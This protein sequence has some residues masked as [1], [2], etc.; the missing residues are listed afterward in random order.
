MGKRRCDGNL[1][2]KLAIDRVSKRPRIAD[3]GKF[4]RL[5]LG[6]RHSLADEVGEANQRQGN[7]ECQQSQVM[8][9]RG[10]QPPRGTRGH[11]R[12]R[13]CGGGVHV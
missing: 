6:A 10:T 9:D 11:R 2:V 13:R 7:N 5:A 12:H 4:D 8:P 1:L 3:E